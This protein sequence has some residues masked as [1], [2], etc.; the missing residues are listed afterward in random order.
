MPGRALSGSGVVRG[1]DR[2]VRRPRQR[3]VRWLPRGRRGRAAALAAV[4]AAGAGG[5]VAVLRWKLWSEGVPDVAPARLTDWFDPGELARNRDYRRGVWTMAVIGIPIGAAA[6]VAVALLGGQWRPLVVRAA[7]AR[8]WRAGA[9]TGAGISVAT[10]LAGLPLSGARFAWGRDHGIVTQSVPGW[11]A[12]LGKGLGV[13]VVVGGLVGSGAAVAIGRLPRTW[14]VALAGGVGALVYLMSLLSPLLLEPLF[15]KTEP[16]RDERL[17]AQILDIAHRAGVQ[18]DDVKV[19]DASTRTTAANAYVSGLGG[20]RH[21][22]LYDTLLRDFPEDQV[23]MVVAHELAHVERHHVLKGSTWGAAL[24]VP[25]CLLIFAVVGWRT[26][27]GRPGTGASG[28][29][30][31]VRRVAIAAAT[32][33]VIGAASAPLSNWVSR[34]YEREAEWRGLQLAGDPQAAIGLQQGLVAKSLGVPDPPAG[35][36]VWFGS[37]PTAL[38]RIGMALRAEREG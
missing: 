6:T 13:S 3:A 2:R 4:A 24:A 5:I 8:Y 27:F 28:C 38:E 32:A 12:D 17:S 10:F 19:N 22:V 23:R 34:A 25:A 31:V 33:A 18:A 26:G 9:L 14:W 35:I 30:V 29:D 36:R 7:R 15:Q 16:L 21:V 1:Y 37:H 11:A 20:S